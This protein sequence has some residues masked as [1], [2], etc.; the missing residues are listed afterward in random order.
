MLASEKDFSSL[1][2]EALILK[3]NNFMPLSKILKPEMKILSEASTVF[4]DIIKKYDKSFQKFLAW[5][6]IEA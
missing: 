4:Y 3:N 5:S 1:T 6:L 2:E